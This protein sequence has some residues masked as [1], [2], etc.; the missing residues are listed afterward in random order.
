MSH[1][2]ANDTKAD[3]Y[4]I[5]FLIVKL[6]F[7]SN[8]SF[9]NNC[10][11]AHI[12]APIFCIIDGMDQLCYAWEPGASH[13]TFRTHWSF[14]CI[15][16]SFRSSLQI[17]FFYLGNYLAAQVSHCSVNYFPN[18]CIS[19]LTPVTILWNTFWT[20]VSK[21]YVSDSVSCKFTVSSKRWYYFNW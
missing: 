2:W 9:V 7:T 12:I 3:A 20:S 16:I 5:S 21:F 4:S 6:S 1:S 10:L 18:D 19:S 14:L 8:S 17:L 13:L 15:V 11:Q